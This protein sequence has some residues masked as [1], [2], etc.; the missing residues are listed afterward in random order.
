MVTFINLE[1]EFPYNL[2]KDILEFDMYKLNLENLLPV[3][4]T[5]TPREHEVI[6][7]RY[8][9]KLTLREIGKQQNVT[10]ERIRQI[11]AKALRKLR[12]SQRKNKLLSVSFEELQNK[13]NEYS[14]LESKYNL[15]QNAYFVISDEKAN[16]KSMEELAEIAINL[17]SQIEYLD[18]SVRTF[19]CLRRAGITTLSDLVSKTE[20]E[21]RK[22]RNLGNKCVGEILYTLKKLNLNLKGE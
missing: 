1:N 20:T 5:L 10:Q 18:F 2:A 6:I 21:V 13:I 17:Q 12:S 3:L 16:S 7:C 4:A 11:S 19:N 9:K 14:D 15:L 8:A 22:I